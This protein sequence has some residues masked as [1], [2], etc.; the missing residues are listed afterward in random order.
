MILPRNRKKNVGPLFFIGIAL[1]SAASLGR[2]FLSRGTHI[3]AASVDGIIGFAF[4]IAIGVMLVGLVR[5]SRRANR[6]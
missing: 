5:Q 3:G 4:G 1:M 2:L 6:C